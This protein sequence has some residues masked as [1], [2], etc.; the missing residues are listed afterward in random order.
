M[1]L[2]KTGNVIK[3]IKINK[4]NVVVVFSNDNKIKISKDLYSSLYLYEGKSLTKKEI[5]KIYKDNS[6]DE[7]YLYA[8]KLI[9]KKQYFKNKIKEKIKVK[10]NDISLSSLN[11][12]IDK[13]FKN[14]LLDDEK[15]KEDYLEYYSSLNYGENRIKD[16]LINLGYDF[17]LTN[18]IV[19]DKEEEI[20]KG[21]NQL[22][23][24]EKKYEKYNNKQKKNKII[25][26]LLTLGFSLDN[27]N[28]IIKDLS[29]NSKEEELELLRKD[30]LKYY[31]SLIRRNNDNI[32]DKLINK[33]LYKGYKYKDIIC[34]MEEINDENSK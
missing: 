31:S 10:F 19:F 27:I 30:L 21:K 17:H 33:L 26:S 23:K 18:E 34:V 1:Q 24:L 28:L 2:E 5:D 6:I 9:A 14:H 4:N 11:Y 25:S 12:V 3:K 7:Y 32:K 22:I 20:V 29:N 13:L 15:L 8:L 16:K